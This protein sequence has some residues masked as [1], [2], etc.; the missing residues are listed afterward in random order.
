MRPCGSA[1]EHALAGY[2]P[3][4]TNASSLQRIA[5]I[6]EPILDTEPSNHQ[7]TEP[8]LLVILLRTERWCSILPN[9]ILEEFVIR[10]ELCPYPFRP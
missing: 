3:G 9:G 6:L 5:S 4:P 8:S 7:Y 10:V 2:H 1:K